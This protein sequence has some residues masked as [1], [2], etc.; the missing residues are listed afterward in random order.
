[1][2]S[3]EIFQHLGRPVVL[4]RIAAKSKAPI[5]QNWPSFTL[6]DMTPAYRATLNGNIGVSLGEDAGGVGTIDVDD[7]HFADEFLALN[8][9]LA[10]TAISNG[11]RGCNLWIAP[12]NC[13]RSCKI[14]TKDGQPWGE[15]RWTGNQTVISGTHPSGVEYRLKGG[16]VVEID[17]SEIVW[18][19]NLVLPWVQEV[20]PPAFS[21]ADLVAKCGPFFWVDQWGNITK[22]NESYIAQ[23]FCLE[24]LVLYEQVEGWF[25]VFDKATGAWRAVADDVVKTMII[26]AWERLVVLFGRPA[27]HRKANNGLF[28][29][30]TNLVRAL[31]GRT[32]VFKRLKRVLHCKNGMLHMEYQPRLMPFSPEYYSRN[33]IPI[34]YNPEAKCPKFLAFLNEVLEPDDVSLLIRWIGSCLLTGN[35]AQRIL[36]L[37]GIAHSGKST[38][39]EIVEHLLGRVNVTALRTDQLGERFEIGRLFGYT[40][41]TAKD[42]P[43]TFMEQRGADVLKRLVGHD[44]TPGERKHGMKHVEVYGDYDCLITC[45]KRL[46]V[47]LDGGHRSMAPAA[48]DYRIFEGHSRLETNRK[49]CRDDL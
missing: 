18:P 8:P 21:E 34:A 5:D 33:P 20:K 43:G 28:G 32:E 14:K 7:D 29:S 26:A 12:A 19:A 30:L 9:R 46:A 16:P 13:P 37:V 45:N 35:V 3:D 23:R 1:M 31:C 38:I 36:I 11:A 44:Y 6:A 39:A 47:K 15:W 27:L 25:F 41:L 24:H 2:T 48:D 10:M 17:F 4:L 40:L 49:F 22:I 42:V